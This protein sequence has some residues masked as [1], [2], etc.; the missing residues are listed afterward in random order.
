MDDMRRVI[1]D[2]FFWDVYRKESGDIKKIFM[3]RI[4]KKLEDR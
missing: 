4:K 3:K 2:V 1:G